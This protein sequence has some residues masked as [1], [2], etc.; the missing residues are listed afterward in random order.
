VAYPFGEAPTLG[1]FI[2]RARDFGAS[3]RHSA[4]V[5]EGPGGRVRFA[6][7]WIDS[8]RF[9]EL[10]NM[11]VDARLSPDMV[12]YMARRLRISTDEFWPGFSGFGSD[13][14]TE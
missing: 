4:A 10:P 3:V 6:Y 7:L 9:V 1:S 11:S 14:P 8:E 2:E 5:V 13:D 12:D